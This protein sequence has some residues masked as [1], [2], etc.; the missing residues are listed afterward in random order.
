MWCHRLCQSMIARCGH[1]ASLHRCE[2]CY[3]A[4][5]LPAPNSHSVNFLPNRWRRLL[6]LMPRSLGDRVAELRTTD[7][8]NYP[9]EVVYTYE[10]NPFIVTVSRTFPVSNSGP[11]RPNQVHDFR[12]ITYLPNVS[13]SLRT[14]TL[15]RRAM[16]G[17]RRRE[18]EVTD[19]KHTPLIRTP[20]SVK[21][22]QANFRNIVQLVNHAVAENRYLTPA[23]PILVDI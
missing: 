18:H 16:S 5:H 20:H 21:L 23:D 8:Q 6:R 9:L 12:Y 3:T 2:A 17:T 13:S 15:A 19:R 14:N 4:L 11:E 22:G 7:A 10:E 1:T